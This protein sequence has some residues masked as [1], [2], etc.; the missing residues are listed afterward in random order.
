M[1]ELMS[2]IIN[3]LIESSNFF[4]FH[5]SYIYKEQTNEGSLEFVGKLKCKNN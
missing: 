3:F 1:Y 4:A 5:S 2:Q